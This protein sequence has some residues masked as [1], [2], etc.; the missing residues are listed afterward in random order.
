MSGWKLTRGCDVG[1]W[2]VGLKPDLQSQCP[3]L[4][5]GAAALPDAAEFFVELAAAC[6]LCFAPFA[7][8]ATAEQAEQESVAVIG[9][10]D[11]GILHVFGILWRTQLER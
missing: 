11:R 7:F 5:A 9:D 8:V 3:E 4:C 6:R 2:D 10:I 1:G